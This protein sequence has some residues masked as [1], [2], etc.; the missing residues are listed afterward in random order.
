M[1]LYNYSVFDTD[2]ITFD[3]DEQVFKSEN[4][5]NVND[6]I[7]KVFK[8]VSLI[9]TNDWAYYMAGPVVYVVI[10]EIDDSNLEYYRMIADYRIDLTTG[11]ISLTFSSLR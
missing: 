2:G 5:E 11:E 4:F 9:S 10:S 3:S 7:V 6:L 8:I 1:K